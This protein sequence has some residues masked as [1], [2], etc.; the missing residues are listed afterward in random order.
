[1]ALKNINLKE[2]MDFDL[3]MDDEEFEEFKSTYD[4]MLGKLS[5]NLFWR[6][7]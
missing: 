6:E 7:E 1:M 5:P 4:K 2:E 3:R